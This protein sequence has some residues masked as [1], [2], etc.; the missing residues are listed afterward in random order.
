MGGVSGTTSDLFGTVLAVTDS[1]LLPA[2][3]IS[4]RV[5]TRRIGGAP[6]QHMT[7]AQRFYA[8]TQ[9]PESLDL[10]QADE[11]PIRLRRAGARRRQSTTRRPR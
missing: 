8:A 9:A 1:L 11:L 6:G 4:S 2:T 7:S 3:R 10:E 5:A